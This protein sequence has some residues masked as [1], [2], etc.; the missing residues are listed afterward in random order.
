MKLHEKIKS[1]RKT[2]SKRSQQEV[3]DLLGVS[4]SAYNMW[5]RGDRKPS[6]PVLQDMAA[7][8]DI[9]VMEFLHIIM[10]ESKNAEMTETEVPKSN[11]ETP[12]TSLR[13]P[14]L[15]SIAAGKP[16]FAEENIETYIDLPNLWEYKSPHE[17]FVLNVK[18]DSMIG[19]RI[20]EGDRVVVKLTPQVENGDIA[21][22][23]VNGHEATLKRV[24]ITDGGQHIL[25]PENSAYDPIII[26]DEDA[27][28]V[29]KVLHVM[30]DPK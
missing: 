3:A 8:Y 21:I 24:K 23:N 14:V 11:G 15:G 19:A 17:L 7:L 30:F 6:I 28:I 4:R 5:E 26:N 2:N 12:P 10:E 20:H 18:G 16:V 13:V 29:G 9:D 1:L 27:R 22:V 25:L